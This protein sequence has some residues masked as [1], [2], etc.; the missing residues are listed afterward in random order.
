MNAL[1]A[2][3]PLLCRGMRG[4][5]FREAVID[6]TGV[7]WKKDGRDMQQ[8]AQPVGEPLAQSSVQSNAV[9][10][11]PPNG[12][13]SRPRER[14][15]RAGTNGTRR[16]NTVQSDVQTSEAEQS[17]SDELD[18]LAAKL[19]RGLKNLVRDV[20]SDAGVNRTL[21]F[22]DAN[23][24]GSTDLP[25][26]FLTDAVGG[27]EK[28]DRLMQKYAAYFGLDNQTDRWR[29]LWFPV[30]EPEVFLEDR[31]DGS[32]ASKERYADML[33][34]GTQMVLSKSELSHYVSFILFLWDLLANSHDRAFFIE[35]DINFIP[36]V[37]HRVLKDGKLVEWDQVDPD[38]NKAALKYGYAP[39]E[40]R[41]RLVRSIRHMD[42][43]MNTSGVDADI[44]YVGSLYGTG[45]HYEIGKET[46]VFERDRCLRTVPTCAVGT[47]A[48]IVTNAG[49]KKLLYQ[50]V[51]IWTRTDSAIYHVK[52]LTRLELVPNLIGQDKYWE[53]YQGVAKST[54]KSTVG[55][56]AFLTRMQLQFGL[57]TASL[58][59]L[60]FFM[61]TRKDM[62]LTLAG[63]MLAL[64]IFFRRFF[65]GR[66]SC[67]RRKPQ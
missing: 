19:P 9:A 42:S 61:L 16:P 32:F 49:A 8:L 11:V 7:L 25:L 34:P 43:K 17:R 26:Y 67:C 24:S 55:L 28:R 36:I 27:R 53:V 64:C 6:Y 51:P 38:V 52:D 30:V 12:S 46:G 54:L 44:V 45:A 31:A 13:A 2:L 15:Y 22:S 41:T 23:M 65:E 60:E 59:P 5:V 33:Y 14:S 56:S 3:L 58:M 1:L 20:W 47:H 66:C 48:L 21:R 63:V 35:D 40:F 57:C 29:S 10:E 50:M 18:E 62:V 39:E 37:D 4:T